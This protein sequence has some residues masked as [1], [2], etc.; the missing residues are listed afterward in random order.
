MQNFSN[1]II[2]SAVNLVNGGTFTILKECLEQISKSKSFSEWKIIALVN[3][4]KLL[5]K[6]NNIEYIE[7]PLAKKNY[8]FRCFYEY[9]YF[10]FLSLKFKPKIWFSLHDMTP[11][12]C[13]EKRYVYMH[14][15]MPFYKHFKGEH[16]SL[17]LKLFEK[18]YKFIYKI[19][20]RKNSAIIVQQDWIRDEISKLCKFP[21]ERIIV[22]YPEINERKISPD[23]EKGL[24]FFPSVPRPFK[25]FETI[26]KADEI[27]EKENLNLNWKIVLTMNGS[28][29]SYSKEL[30]E[31]YSYLK[32]IDFVGLLSQEKVFEYYNK[33]ECLI[34]P[35][36]LETWGLPISEFKSSGKKMILA[37]LLYAYETANNAK[38]VAW[39]VPDD[40]N[41]LSMIIKNVLNNNNSDFS[42]LKEKV[43]NFPHAISWQELFEEMQFGNF[44]IKK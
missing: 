29:N 41:K 42:I 30:Y 25:N 43:I 14:N 18:F 38:N 17:K 31:K 35:S 3:S 40:A 20:S 6:Y 5:Q 1:T 7:Y 9:V 11:N 15:P 33:A 39:F 36:R 32:N 23:Y 8:F 4:K 34:F 16:L 26:L 44:S 22:S 13:A 2:I 27:L 21:K 19:N 24:F 12:V 37:D 10:Y 28:E